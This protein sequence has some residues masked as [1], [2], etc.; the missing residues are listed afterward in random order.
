MPDQTG[1]NIT[2]AYKA[3][4]V[5][6]TPA[7]G[8]GA[9]V[10]RYSGGAG[11]SLSK[12]KIRSSESRNDGMSTLG[13]HG[14]RSVAGGYNNAVSLGTF[15]PLFAG[16]MRGAWSAP[17]VVTQATAGLT[18]ITTVADGI[19]ASAGSFITAG[20]KVGDVV[21]LTDHSTVANNNRNLRL[22]GVSALKLT[23]AETLTVNAV[24][25]TT[26]TITRPKKLVNPAAPIRQLFTFEEYEQDLDASNLF[27]DVR[28]ASLRLRLGAENELMSEFGLVG[29]DQQ[30]LEGAAAPNFT[31]PAQTA[32]IGLVAADAS[33]RLG[34]QTLATLTAFDIAF[35]NNAR[36]HPVA[37]SLVS[38]DVYE[39]NLAPLTGTISC[40]REDME[41]LKKFIAEEQLSL[42]LL[43]AEP[44]A[45]PKDFFSL[46]VPL[47]TLDGNTKNLGQDG[48]LIQSIPFEAGVQL[49]SAGGVNDVTMAAFQS[50]AA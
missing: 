18:S 22:V 44:D 6:G 14:H 36:T 48:P 24:A 10:F 29:R 39:G 31:S 38:R 43:F 30:V 45:E 26:F 2:V 3:Q 35:N 33:I 17:L 47:L 32:S 37:G 20:F 49:N 11:L 1:R 23:T 5:L 46:Y 25:D 9:T 13:R 40:I 15:D 27:P 21:R 12:N 28:V 19:V 42:H 34:A 4:P 16:I 50:S 8:A 41:L 7:T